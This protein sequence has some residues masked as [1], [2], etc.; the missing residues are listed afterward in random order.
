MSELPDAREAA[1]GIADIFS[2]VCM[3]PLMRPLAGLRL[4]PVHILILVIAESRGDLK[5]SEVAR[6]LGMK[7]SAF[8]LRL[9]TMLDKGLIDIVGRGDDRRLRFLEITDD[10]NELLARFKKR[11]AANIE[12]H[13]GR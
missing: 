9:G 2:D 11:V 13:Y 5:L 10:G 12:K 3:A 7:V 8:S 6:L 1:E 4:D